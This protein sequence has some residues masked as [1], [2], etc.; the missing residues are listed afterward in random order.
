MPHSVLAGDRIGTVVADPFR[1]T[2][3]FSIVHAELA[4]GN[5]ARPGELL[6]LEADENT[7]T[8]GR[9]EGGRDVNPYETADQ[10]HTRTLL[11]MESTSRR[12]DMPRRYRL[13]ELDLI[14]EI[15]E[16]GGRVKLREPQ[17]L[18]EAGSAVF[19]PNPNIVAPAL[20]LLPPGDPS[21][22]SGLFVGTTV[23]GLALPV[24][25]KPNEV[26]S[27]HVLIVGTTGTGKSYLRGVLA[28]E[29]KK[30]GIAQVA[31]D[32][33][34]E[35]SDATTELGGVNLRP[36]D[37]LTVKLSSLS[38]PEVMGFIPFLTELQGEIVRRAFLEL[39]R[40]S[41]REG[42]DFSLDDLLAEIDLVGPRM[43]AR[44]STM[45]AARSRAEMLRFVKVIGGGVNWPRLLRSGSI[46]NIDCRGLEHSELE[47]VAGGVARELLSLRMAKKIPPL[48]LS[49]DEA[50][51]FLP[52]SED[53]PSSQVI[54][55][56]IRFGRHY[57]IGLALITPS[58]MDIDRRIVRTTNCRFIFSTE[59]DQLDALK[60]V[61]ADTPDELIARLP[62]LEQGTC[63]LTGSKETI[64]HSILIR[65]RERKT[66]H[67]GKTPDFVGESKSFS[68]GAPGDA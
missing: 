28:E 37:G 3:S 56:V 35:S 4:P 9:V 60:G 23:G 14:E 43:E 45:S 29:I 42:T 41:V 39:K 13:I 62:K 68:G 67:G 48:V 44:A 63:L 55:E 51:L 16:D 21:S 52:H 57:G 38:E 11:E 31:V 58:P 20:G 49:I 30:L 6:L 40:R 33:H 17:L 27:R 47:A 54:R 7:Y 22:A 53:V 36:G 25:L 2:P 10:V 46:V 65:V 15:Q 5:K 8:L 24:V 50:H 18:V 61:F 59:P 12:D 19:R 66:T 1:G 64:R 32:V 34:G 26:L